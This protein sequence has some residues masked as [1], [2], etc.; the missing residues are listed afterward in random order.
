MSVLHFATRQI[1]L[2]DIGQ[3]CPLVAAVL[4]PFSTLFDIPA[5]TQEWFAK[6]DQPFPDVHASLV[7]SAVGLAFNVVANGLL[8]VR[9]S[10]RYYLWKI[11]TRVSL[12]C[13]AIKVIVALIN[14]SVF[15]SRSKRGDGFTYLEA[16]WCAVVSVILS[17]FITIALLIHWIVAFHPSQKEER[18]TSSEVRITGRHFMLQVTWLVS[19]IGLGALIFSRIEDWLYFDGIYFMVVSSLTV[20]FGDFEPTTTAG[21]IILFPFLFFLVA[22]LANAIGMIIGFFSDKSKD[23]Q[24]RHLAEM[25]KQYHERQDKQNPT[26]NL[27]EEIKFLDDVAKMEETKQQKRDIVRSVTYFVTF[28][29]VGAAIFSQLEQW[30]YGDGLY[31]CYIFFLTV[32]YGDFA[33]QSN[34]GRVVFV[35]YSLIAVPV[36]ASFAVQTITSTLQLVSKRRLEHRRQKHD[37]DYAK[38]DLEKAAR[39]V[40]LPHA[41]LVARSRSKSQDDQGPN[42]DD[43]SGEKTTNDIHDAENDIAERILQAGVQLEG[44]ARRLLVGLMNADDDNSQRVGML[45]KADWNV[46][47]REV[48]SLL[49]PDAEEGLDLDGDGK[50]DFKPGAES[51][52]RRGVQ[53]PEQIIAELK[54][55]RESFATLLAAGSTLKK[56]EG[57]ERLIFER[58]R[59]IELAASTSKDRS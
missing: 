23:A 38:K 58:R 35:V 15:G 36:M 8:I 57:K 52:L 47:R 20:G 37:E 19:A 56:L 30:T 32:G 34:A 48:L 5:L 42:Q 18:V 21:R 9:F 39:H 40:F 22:Q 59:E 10:S 14:L 50:G 13:W 25:E 55:Y 6:D 54:G 12:L 51:D 3:V 2:Q 11:T 31:F 16:F 27:D 28:W 45:L 4:A 43:N 17:G 49:G 7:L 24:S 53:G 33:P 29:L 44:H 1:N 26:P 46:Q 41:E